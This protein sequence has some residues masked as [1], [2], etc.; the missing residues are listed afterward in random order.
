MLHRE[1]HVEQGEF[2][3]QNFCCKTRIEDLETG[4]ED[5]CVL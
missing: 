3:A 4:Y 2:S 5:P 1:Q